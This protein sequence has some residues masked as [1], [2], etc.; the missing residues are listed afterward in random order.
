GPFE[1]P[2]V[3]VRNAS[4]L[5]TVR[6]F[7]GPRSIGSTQGF[8]PKEIRVSR[9]RWTIPRNPPPTNGI[10]N[11]TLSVA[12]QVDVVQGWSVAFDV[13]QA[14]NGGGM[15]LNITR[16]PGNLRYT[17]LATQA[18]GFHLDTYTRPGR[19]SDDTIAFEWNN[20]QIRSIDLQVR[21]AMSTTT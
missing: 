2:P 18:A 16:M 4:L 20:A 17:L 13:P 5:S 1:N 8:E 10:T 6:G 14:Q 15:R 12:A 7:F 9:G 11:D 19:V 21:D 3:A